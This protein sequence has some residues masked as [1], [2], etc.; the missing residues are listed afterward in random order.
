VKQ[1][2]QSLFKRKPTLSKQV[3]DD[4][5]SSSS[6]SLVLDATAYKIK[7]VDTTKSSGRPPMIDLST[8]NNFKELDAA[9]K[10]SKRQ[11]IPT[12]V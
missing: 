12:N 3:D 9:L 10:E 5:L 6:A 7:R 11:S 2:Q 8:D 4:Q 1:A